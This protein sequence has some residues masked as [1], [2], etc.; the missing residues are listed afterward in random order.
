MHHCLSAAQH[1][2]LHNESIVSRYVDENDRWQ[3]GSH[4]TGAR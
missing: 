1:S 4:L 2:E 3:T